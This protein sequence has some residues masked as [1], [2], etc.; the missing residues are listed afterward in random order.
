MAVAARALIEGRVEDSVA[1]VQAMLSP[2][3][4]D[5]EGRFYIARHIA[6]HGDAEQALAQLDGIVADGFI[7]HPVL[8][9]DP[10]FDA[11]RG[12]AAFTRLLDQCAVQHN[13]A[14]AAF[15]V[16]DGRAVLGVS[17]S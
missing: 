5:P 3:F 6:R 12:S 9:S 13:A 8:A 11:L 4:R 14:V 15:E 16:L 17:S 7:C 10:W 2:D 1:A